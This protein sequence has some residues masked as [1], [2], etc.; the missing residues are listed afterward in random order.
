MPTHEVVA[1]DELAADGER[2]RA[3][4]HVDADVA[5]RG[6]TGE[7]GDLVAEVP[8]VRQR[9]RLIGRRLRHDREDLDQTLWIAHRQRAEEDGVDEREDRGVG[10]DAQRERDDD[11]GRQRLR[12]ARRTALRDSSAV[13]SN[14]TQ[15][16]EGT[17]QNLGI[18]G[19]CET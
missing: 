16:L 13:A 15:P 8:V 18:R 4:G 11:D 19:S 2:L 7:L 9:Q 17:D 6:Q 3:T 5:P 1:G 10:A 12:T 14:S